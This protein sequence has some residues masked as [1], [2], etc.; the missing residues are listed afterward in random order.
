MSQMK[1][2]EVLQWASLFLEKH[3]REQRVAEILLQHHLNYSRNDFF[4]NMREP[5]DPNIIQRFKRDVEKHVETGMPIQHL[6][7]YEEFYGRK[8]KVNEHVLVPRPETEELVQHV[9]NYIETTSSEHQIRVVDVGTGS[10]VIAI[11][12]ALQLPNAMVYATDISQEALQVAK[13]NAKNHQAQ[14]TFYQGNF[15]QPL[16]DQGIKTDIIVSNPPYIP[17]SEEKTLADTVKNFDPDMALYAEENG[18]AAYKEIISQ[19]T[20][21][22]ELNGYIAVEI[23]HAQSESVND[24]IQK[25]YPQSKRNTIQDINGKDRIVTAK[26]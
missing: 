15:L 5:I 25:I 21:V 8:F 17:R 4:M 1:Q 3:H 24:I 19:S 22:L 10:G 16:I 12:L 6:M 23:G 26:L 11:S 14:V 9:A 18:L 7:G 13:T 20:S 2:Y